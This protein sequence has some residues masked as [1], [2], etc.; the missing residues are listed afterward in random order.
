MTSDQVNI[1]F[2]FKLFGTEGKPY[3]NEEFEY[4]YFFLKG[5]NL[6]NVREYPEDYLNYLKS[7]NLKIPKFTP[8]D[9][10]AQNWWGIETPNSKKLNSK[11]FALETAKKLG[12]GPLGVMK[13]SSIQEIE[14]ILKAQPNKNFFIRDPYLAAG[15]NSLIINE[16][17]F[18]QKKNNLLRFLS[19]RELI[20]APYFERLMDLG[21]IFEDSKVD[22]F[23]NLN[24][25]DGKFKGGIV[26]EK[27][28]DLFTLLS[29]KL[30]F[31]RDEIFYI[32]RQIYNHYLKNG[33]KGLVQVDSFFYN[34]EG[35]IKYYPLVEVNCR[36]TFGLFINN[37][38]HF[39]PEGGSGIYLNFLT[40]DLFPCKSFNQRLEQIGNLR[41]LDKEGVIPLSP[42][43]GKFSSFFISSETLSALDLLVKELWHK[44][45]LGDKD[46]SPSLIL[47]YFI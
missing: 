15:V 2:E 44:I 47:D 5:K 23:W 36:K 46:L 27:D 25:R 28:N 32:Q 16:S 41:Y 9:V 40:K 8:G 3:I 38:R 33:A 17:N 31:K 10:K 29:K 34:E 1:D 45:S 37:L 39:L 22:V 20:M 7:L 21:F 26:F 11:F 24:S 19:K 43:D 13:V 35:V 18:D 12:L 42:Q 30:G 14:K 6:A 4:V